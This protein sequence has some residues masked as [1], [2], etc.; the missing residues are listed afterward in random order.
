MP[1][2][3]DISGRIC[4][5]V[6]PFKSVWEAPESFLECSALSDQ[7][8]K[9]YN[10]TQKYLG[11]WVK[12]DCPDK[13]EFDPIRQRC[14]DKRKMHRQP[15]TAPLSDD[16]NPDGE[17]RCFSPCRATNEDPKVGGLCNWLSAK[18]EIDPDSNAHFLQCAVQNTGK[19]CGEWVRMPCAEGTVFH[20]KAQLCIPEPLTANRTKRYCPSAYVPVCQC[21]DTSTTCPGT[22]L[23]EEGSCCMPVDLE[24]GISL[25][26]AMV[27]HSTPICLGGTLPIAMCSGGGNSCP[28]SYVCQPSVG[29]CPVADLGSGGQDLVLTIKVCPGTN[30]YPI[31]SCS[32]CPQGMRCNSHL[33]GC[34]PSYPVGS[35][36]RSI[37]IP[38]L[39]IR[40]AFVPYSVS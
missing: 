5:T 24:I 21:G 4:M 36:E 10:I 37:E 26:P 8:V 20:K 7:E 22:A 2:M 38:I 18:L 33:G 17:T 12:R 6:E 16:P 35:Y 15:C 31:G 32:A 34:C 28:A 13:F 25:G 9:E 27:Q 23:C 19:S 1:T 11:V 3:P 30:S 40:T 14:L 39:V 29:C